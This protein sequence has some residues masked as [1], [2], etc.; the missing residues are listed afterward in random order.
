MLDQLYAREEAALA[1]Y[2]FPSRESRGRVW[3]EPPHPYRLPFQR[4]RDRVVHSVAFRRLSEKMQVFSHTVHDDH[5]VRLTHTMEVTMIARTV[6]RSL[7]LNGDI[8]E[9]L[10]LFHDIGHPAFGHEGERV[11]NT[12]LAE[13][14][15]FDHNAQALRIAEKLEQRYPDFPG[16]NLSCEVLDGQRYKS[17]KKANA[18]QG[19]VTSPP[20]LEVQV[21]DWADSISYDAHD[22]DDALALGYLTPSDLEATRLGRRVVASLHRRWTNLVGDD[23][24]RAAVHE[25][26]DVVVGS[27][28]RT[29]YERLDLLAPNSW[30]AAQT[31]GL[32][33]AP[34]DDLVAEIAE[35]EQFLKERVYRH[36]QVLES[37]K[38]AAEQVR[39]LFA[40]HLA[41]VDSLPPRYTK[42]VRE[43]SPERAVADYIADLTDRAAQQEYEQCLEGSA[44]PN[45]NYQIAIT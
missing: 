26:I 14:G 22:V 43:E 13:H 39:T 16:M 45:R 28:I 37:R 29:S 23:L 36:P 20:L 17:I 19:R 10:A 30:S 35:W 24:R 12:L 38:L 11:L 33:I 32:V 41:R 40:S 42:V 5:R 31:L 44:M 21:V 2:A 4:D 18:A 6:G 15:G 8:V 25:I 27:L 1:A 3:P 9:A 7:A 34:E